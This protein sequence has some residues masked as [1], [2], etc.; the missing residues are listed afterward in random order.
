MPASDSSDA[1]GQ[2]AL[3]TSQ[4]RPADRQSPAGRFRLHL[5]LLAVPGCLLAGWFELTRARHGREIAWVYVVE[6]PLFAAIGVY[7]W[8]RLR[9]PEAAQDRSLDPAQ[10]PG[11][12]ATRSADGRPPARQE[13]ADADPE[14]AAW[15]AYLAALHA[16][17]PPGGP[18]PR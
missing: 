5:P 1:A 6:W 11:S 3:R 18:P 16:A 9:T 4:P 7:M 8:W 15:Q 14:L 2:P 12:A 17:D 10:R 13:P